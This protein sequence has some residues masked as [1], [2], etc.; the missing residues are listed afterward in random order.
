[1]LL[2]KIMRASVQCLQPALE[3]ISD[4]LTAAAKAKTMLTGDT[5]LS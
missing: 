1:M 2:T 5:T 4:E 3:C